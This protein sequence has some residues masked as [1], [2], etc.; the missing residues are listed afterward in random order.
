MSGSSTSFGGTPPLKDRSATHLPRRP[1]HSPTAGLAFW[2][3]ET[4]EDRLAEDGGIVCYRHRVVKLAA[5]R[6][7]D[8]VKIRTLKESDV[9]FFAFA[10]GRLNT[11]IIGRAVSEP[12]GDLQNFAPKALGNHWRMMHSAVF[13]HV[14]KERGKSLDLI[15]AMLRPPPPKRQSD[16]RYREGSFPS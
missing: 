6:H 1:E 11:A 14:M 16:A 10:P 15:P 5:G 8:D 2:L 9:A 4:F 13:Q 7:E 3:G 12:L